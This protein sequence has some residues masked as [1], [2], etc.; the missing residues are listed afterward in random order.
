MMRKLIVLVMCISFLF[1]SY[2]LASDDLGVEDIRE[3]KEQEVRDIVL[4]MTFVNSFDY[5][6]D[7]DLELV[8]EIIRRLTPKRILDKLEAGGNDETF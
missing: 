2:G 8:E 7:I 3:M 1:S 6:E 4:L 5:T